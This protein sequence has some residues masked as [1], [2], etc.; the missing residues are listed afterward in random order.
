MWTLQPYDLQP[1]LD[2][3]SKLLNSAL[4]RITSD[5]EYSVVM[6]IIYDIVVK[7]A[8]MSKMYQGLNPT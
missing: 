7:N 6:V 4:F 2:M 5:T 3:K 1:F 8:H